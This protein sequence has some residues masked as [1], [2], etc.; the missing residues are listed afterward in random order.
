MN[1]KFLSYFSLVL[2]LFIL[3]LGSAEAA[4]YIPPATDIDTY[5]GEFTTDVGTLRTKFTPLMILVT[6]SLMAF[7]LFKRFFRSSLS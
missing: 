4:S 3:S 5:V 2:S 1:V 7:G 6:G